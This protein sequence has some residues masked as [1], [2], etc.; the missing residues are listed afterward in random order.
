[1]RLEFAEYLSTVT[2]LHALPL[3][4]TALRL[5]EPPPGEAAP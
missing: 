4:P 1:M 5:A 3:V 2:E